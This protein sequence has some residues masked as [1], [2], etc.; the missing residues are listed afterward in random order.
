MSYCLN[1]DCPRPGQNPPEAVTCQACG[2]NIVL[3]N[4]YRPL[5]PL[6]Q[7]GFGRTFLAVDEDKPSKP[8]CVVK[9]FLPM[10]MDAQS[11]AKASE[12]F[13]R[14]AVRLDELGHHE[15]I[16]KL[17]AYFEQEQ[18]Q[19]IIQEFI[20]GNNLARELQLQ[21]AFDEAKA[22]KLLRDLV[23]VL[24]FVHGHQV[25]HRDVKPEN[26]IRSG[27]NG[28][29]YLVDFGA[30][31]FAPSTSM[32]NLR[33]IISSA[34]FTAPEQMVGK[35]EF[36]SDLYSLGVTCVHLMTGRPPL[37]L[38]DM[39]QDGWVWQDYVAEPVSA[40]LAQILQRLL[41]RATRKRYQSAVEVRQDLEA[42]NQGSRLGTPTGIRPTP[43]QA[44]KLVLNF[45]Q[46][47]GGTASKSKVA[48]PTWEC[49]CTLGPY[50]NWVTAVATV[51][52]VGV[53][54]VMAAAGKDGI[55]RVWQLSGQE[56]LTVTTLWSHTYTAPIMALQ[57]TPDAQYIVGGCEDRTVRVWDVGKGKIT[58]T[59][60]GM[61]AK[62]SSP[63]CAIAI[64][65]NGRLVASG[66][67]DKTIRIWEVT[68]GK[69]L[70]TLTGH[71]SHV[72]TLGFT[73][74]GFL[75]VSGGW[76]N[77]LVIWE[78]GNG[79]SLR[80]IAEP[81]RFGD[82]GFNAVVI[83]PDSR[84]IAS[85]NENRLI[86]LWDFNQGERLHSFPEQK[87]AVSA[88]AFSP[89]GNI[90]VSGNQDGLIQTWDMVLRQ[91]RDTLKG[92]SK[93]VTSLAF[94]PDG[95]FLLSGSRD[96]SVRIWRQP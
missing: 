89:R 4:R 13:Q 88:L 18:R 78:A 77:T 59:L 24:E 34:G 56:H 69:C 93:Q 31:K 17:Y 70:C 83:S 43:A 50:S 25:I 28:K 21:G 47:Q 65:P 91:Q 61:F 29:L 73:P 58:Q 16:P 37:E 44:P 11:Y 90:L 46:R 60:G 67:E 71:S 30:A 75:L 95:Q 10:E 32:S 1:P 51:Q 96:N 26:L 53:G 79:R 72:R 92:H 86:H 85:G 55:L 63:I 57:F 8:K 38:Y 15:Q 54:T 3:Q 40:G 12:L 33:T 49:V 5:R 64:S 20:D 9:Q 36:V 19:Y 22:V 66:S 87:T 7:G 74:D 39:A 35:A 62:H 2:S 84:W 76:D 81:F 94:T 48:A 68:S 14:E 27:V 45:P 41:E 23:P 80:T 42:L 82:N 6:G 52:G